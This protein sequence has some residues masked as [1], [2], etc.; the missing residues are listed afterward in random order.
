MYDSNSDKTNT[1]LEIKTIWVTVFTSH[2]RQM[3]VLLCEN[4]RVWGGT[5]LGFCGAHTGS[6]VTPGIF[7]HT[8]FTVLVERE[9]LNS[10]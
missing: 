6:S 7:T 4:Q 2:V 10:S 3:V 8:E 1:I 5:I 9:E